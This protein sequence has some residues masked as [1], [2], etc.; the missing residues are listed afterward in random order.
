MLPV[1]KYLL[2]AIL[3]MPA[4]GVAG[5]IT[6]PEGIAPQE[7]SW[8]KENAPLLRCP[9]QVIQDVYYFRWAIFRRHLHETPAGWVVSEFIQPGP[10]GKYGTINAAAGHHLYEGR[11]LRDG[12]FLDGYSRFWF[13]DPEAKPHLYAEWL[14]DAIWAR[15]CVTGDF[16]LPRDLLPGL[17]RNYRAWEESSLHPSGLYWSHDLADAMEFSI[18]GDGFRPTLNSYQY[19]NARAIARIAALASDQ[20]LAA[21]FTGKADE[22]RRLVQARLW[23]EDARFFKVYPLSDA[24]SQSYLKVKGKNR[25]LP[26]QERATVIHDWSFRQV[27]PERNV[28]EATG[29]LPWYFGL[30]SPAQERHEAWAQL[31]DPGGFWGFYGPTTAERRHSG[32]K[33]A[34]PTKGSASICQWNGPSWPFA[35]SQTLTALANFL[36]RYPPQKV[37]SHADYF[38]LLKAYAASH[39]VHSPGEPPRLFLHEDL[40]P[41]TGQWIVYEYRKRHEPQRVLIGQDYNHSTFNDLVISGLL[42]LEPTSEGLLEIRPLLPAGTWPWFEIR[43]VRVWQHDVEVRYDATGAQFGLGQ[44]LMVWVDGVKLAGRPDL[45]PLSVPLKQTSSR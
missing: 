24:S 16:Q 17:V 14:A 40:D 43:R 38:H 44:G 8:I 30:P 13:T 3:L 18:S 10:G 29:Y 22:L 27:A 36:R 6:F 39:F 31:R 4:A 11:W 19:G 28:R 12:R 26:D 41:D 42:G 15:A 2:A 1:V 25:R 9:D 32:F 23:D 5:E 37:V 21:E 45:G 34:A 7:Q 20:V 33:V 35:T